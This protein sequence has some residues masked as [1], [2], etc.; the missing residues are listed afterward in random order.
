MR[1]GEEEAIGAEEDGAEEGLFIFKAKQLALVNP[2]YEEK[3]FLG[4]GRGRGG[5][6]CDGVALD[7]H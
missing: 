3:F 2:I 5:F 1:D 6:G 7:T 4:G